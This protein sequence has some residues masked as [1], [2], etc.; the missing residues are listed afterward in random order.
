M[1]QCKKPIKY[2]DGE[3]NNMVISKLVETKDNSSYLIGYIDKV[4]T[5]LVLIL[6][7]MGGHVKTLKVKDGE[8]DEENK[9]QPFRVDDENML[10]YMI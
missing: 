2:W 3:V 6:P 9:L 4:I 5:L 10:L 7:K 1:F 8:K